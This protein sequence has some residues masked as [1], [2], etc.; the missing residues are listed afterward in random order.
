MPFFAN[1]MCCHLNSLL[2]PLLVKGIRK[3]VPVYGARIAIAVTFFT[4]NL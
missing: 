4:E 3:R 2:F 1:K